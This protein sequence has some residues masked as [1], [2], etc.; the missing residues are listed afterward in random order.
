[1]EELYPIH[2]PYIDFYIFKGVQFKS[3]LSLSEICSRINKFFDV[4]N[5]SFNKSTI[6]MSSH[7]HTGGV[8]P[9]NSDATDSLRS[10]SASFN[11]TKN[12]YTWYGKFYFIDDEWMF[13]NFEINIYSTNFLNEYIVEIKK[14]FWSDQALFTA[15]KNILEE[16]LD[17]AFKLEYLAKEEKVS[18]VKL[19]DSLISITI[20]ELDNRE[21]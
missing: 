19:C 20:D 6:N 1:M 5:H 9:Y 14:S 16:N 7:H 3:T 15:I 12:K 21:I 18:E 13:C 8:T 17:D 2:K 10:S 4:L 11:F